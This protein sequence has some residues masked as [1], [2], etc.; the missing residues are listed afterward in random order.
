M[1]LDFYTTLTHFRFVLY[2]KLQLYKLQNNYKLI[3]YRTFSIEN[4]YSNNIIRFIKNK[5]KKLNVNCNSTIK[6]RHDYILKT[7]NPFTRTLTCDPGTFSLIRM[8]GCRFR[9]HDWQPAFLGALPSVTVPEGSTS[10]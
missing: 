9:N 8:R 5:I 3:K 1:T 6:K 7:P 2:C 4:Y 10:R